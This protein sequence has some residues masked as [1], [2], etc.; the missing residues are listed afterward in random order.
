MAAIDV[1]LLKKQ[2]FLGNPNTKMITKEAMLIN[3]IGTITSKI[4][5]L[6]SKITNLQL[7]FSYVADC[8]SIR[9]FFHFQHHNFRYGLASY[10][11]FRKT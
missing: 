9:L 11:Q 8:H 7:I 2:E 10:Q 3:I 5:F 6:S 4:L 1:S